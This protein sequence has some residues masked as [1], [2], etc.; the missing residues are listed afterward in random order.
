MSP[1]K[2][3]EASFK[4]P[5]TPLQ[6]ISSC[7]FGSPC[8][9]PECRRDQW[10]PICEICGAHPTAYQSSRDSRDRGG[11]RSYTLTSLCEQCWQ[12]RERRCRAEEEKDEQISARHKARVARMLDNVQRILLTEQVPIVCAVDKFMAEVKPVYN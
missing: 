2:R 7:D 5:F 12:I 8:D 4:S 9:C 1:F 6:S 3:R 11:M 10:K